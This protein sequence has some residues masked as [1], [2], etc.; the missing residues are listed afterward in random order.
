MSI[1]NGW[2]FDFIKVLQFKN[3]ADPKT[4]RMHTQNPKCLPN[5]GRAFFSGFISVMPFGTNI[6]HQGAEYVD[7]HPVWSGHHCHSSL[8][9]TPGNRNQPCSECLCLFGAWCQGTVVFD[10]SQCVCVPKIDCL[11]NFIP[12]IQIF[13]HIHMTVRCF[14][15]HGK[16]SVCSTSRNLS[17]R[18]GCRTFFQ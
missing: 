14:N 4:Q 2:V 3:Q 13:N 12:T 6:L 18:S 1:Y 10:W 17:P 15:K 11:A 7:W 16:K 8:M 9:A 5:C